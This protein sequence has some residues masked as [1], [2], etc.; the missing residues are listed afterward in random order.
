M[1]NIL[2]GFKETRVI[3]QLR[4]KFPGMRWVYIAG[5]QHWANNDGWFVYYCGGMHDDDGAPGH[6]RRSDTREIVMGF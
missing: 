1:S 4:A 6:Y 2:D 3:D 5:H